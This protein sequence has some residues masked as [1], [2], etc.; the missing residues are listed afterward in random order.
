[1]ENWHMR[2]LS[3]KV[4]LV[5]SGRKLFMIFW[6]VFE[7][8]EN[9]HILTPGKLKYTN[10]LIWMENGHM[11]ELS[12]KSS[13]GPRWE[14]TSIFSISWKVFED[15]ENP[16]ILTPGQLK[17]T[18]SLVWME[19]RHMSEL[20][21]KSYP[22]PR[23]SNISI[24]SIIWKVFEYEENPHIRTT[25]QLKYTNSLIW[26]KNGHMSELSQKN[27]PD[28][29]WAKNSIFSIFWKVFENEENP[30]ILTPGQL[31][32]TNSFI[33]MENGHMSEL[34]LQISPNPQWAKTW[35][36]SIFWKVF[37]NEEYPHILTPG[38]LKYTNS[39]I[40]MENGHMSEL[41]QKSLPG[42]R[43]AKTS[44]FFR[45]FEKFS[46]MKN[47][48]IFS[49]QD[50]LNIQIHSFGWKM[51]TWVNWAKKLPQIRGGRKL[52]FFRFFESFRKWR[53]SSYSHSRTTKIYKFT[54]L[55]GKWADEWIETKKFPRSAV[56]E[57][58]NFFDFLKS[59][60]KW[61]KSSYSHSRTT[62]I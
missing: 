2:E 47:I 3:K 17:Y 33:W 22:G 55:D 5:R 9:P 6:E 53:K 42:P 21:Q 37:E 58:F 60:W 8:E 27:S 16:H 46:K 44:I 56:G 19:N 41:S 18:N 24:F 31:K 26:M 34:S 50:K 40:W 1:M 39:L 29:R 28:P 61:R 25:G 43:W 13:L 20:S 35:I 52:Q 11:S 4:P 51:G 62:K 48:L 30:R 32:Y 38:Q 45:F 10:S 57:N 59:F 23:W 49:L 14:K 15:E 54:H 36:F 12:Q 7:N